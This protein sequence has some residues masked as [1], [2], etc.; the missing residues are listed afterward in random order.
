MSQEAGPSKPS[1]RSL[2][3]Q[4]VDLEDDE[5]GYGLDDLLPVSFRNM[6]IRN[7]SLICFEGARVTLDTAI[8]L[9]DLYFTK[10]DSAA[11]P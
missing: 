7:R 11:H 10:R 8:F 5:E 4:E 3:H 6:N 2:D 1:L 9:F